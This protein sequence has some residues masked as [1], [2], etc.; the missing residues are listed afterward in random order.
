MGMHGAIDGDLGGP[1]FQSRTSCCGSPDR[2]KGEAPTTWPY[3]HYKDATLPGGE[4][5]PTDTPGQLNSH[6]DIHW[7]DTVIYYSNCEKVVPKSPYCK[8]NASI[9]KCAATLPFRRRLLRGL[10]G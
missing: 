1:F 3:P 7:P 2:P 4:L 6:F 8:A 5:N 10:A 9:Y